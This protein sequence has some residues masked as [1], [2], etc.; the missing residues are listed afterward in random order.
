MVKIDAEGFDL[1]VLR[2]ASGL[3]GKTEIFLWRPQ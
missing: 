3:L 2:G 1:R